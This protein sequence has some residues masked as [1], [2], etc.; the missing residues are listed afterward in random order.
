A[1]PAYYIKGRFFRPCTKRVG[2]IV[3]V[4]PGLSSTQMHSHLRIKEGIFEVEFIY[5]PQASIRL[6]GFIWAESNLLCLRVTTV[7]DLKWGDWSQLTMRKLPDA[8]DDT[9]PDPRLETPFQNVVAITQQIPGDEVISPFSWTMAGYLPGPRTDQRYETIVSLPRSN[10]TADYFIA[11]ATTRDSGNTGRA[12]EMALRAH[13]QGYDALKVSQ[14]AWWRDF[15]RRSSVDLEDK[16]LENAWFRDLYFLACNLREG[17]QAPGLFG[18]MTLWDAAMWHNDYHMDKNFQKNFYPVLA[19]N[20]CEM[21]EPYFQAILDYLPAAEWRAQQDFGIEGAFIDVSIIPYQ[22]PQRMYINNT[23]GR[24]L[25]LGG[26]TLGQFWWYYQYTKDK[27][28][29]RRVGYPVIKSVTMFYWNYLEKYQERFGGDIFPSSC[30]ENNP[31]YRNVFQ[32]LLF[33]RFAFRVAFQAAAVLAVDPEWQQ[34]WADGLKRVPPYNIIEYDGRK[35]IADHKEQTAKDIYSASTFLYG[36]YIA[37]PLIFPGEDVDPESDTE[38]VQLIREAV[39]EF[40]FEDAFTHN[41][42]SF[43]LD[44]PAARLKMPK[45]YEMV[46]NAVIKCRYPTGTP[47]MFNLEDGMIALQRVYPYGLQVE[48][49]AMPFSITELLFQSYGEVIRLFPAW[50]K[51]KRASFTSLRAEGGFLVSSS[52]ENGTIGTTTIASTIGGPC[53]VSWS[54][55]RPV[56]TAGHGGTVPGHEEAVPFDIAGERI[57]FDTQP[58]QSYTIAPE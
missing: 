1:T 21:S 34:R 7:G 19:A 15:W 10:A 8:V 44:V 43:S 52:L 24:Q 33:F 37:G 14:V 2:E 55:G 45:A 40:K 18:N 9:I 48:D 26:W 16:D 11:V 25:G 56:I 22:P 17:K 38:L 49:F 36:G 23:N 3:L 5:N 41:F 35:R 54:W 13:A 27:D 58:G 51:D 32:D 50:P 12:A 46:R 39:E 28:W 30:L 47:A 31:V 4:G 57:S 53:R 20:H 6:E 42:L 29:L